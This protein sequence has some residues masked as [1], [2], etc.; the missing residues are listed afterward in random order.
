MS[1]GGQT[2]NLFYLNPDSNQ[3]IKKHQHEIYADKHV[4]DKHVRC[5]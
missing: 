4:C 1:K 2:M 5:Y 3:N